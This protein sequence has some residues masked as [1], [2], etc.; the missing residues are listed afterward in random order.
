VNNKITEDLIYQFLINNE[1]LEKLKSNINTFNPFKILK[2]QEHEIRHSNIISWVFDPEGNHNLDDKVFKR[3][4]LEIILNPENE[5]NLIDSLNLYELQ[6]NSYMDIKVFRE[7]DNIDLLLVS[8]INKTVIFIENKVNSN[9]HSNQLNRYFDIVKEKYQGYKLI[10]VY[11]T[12]DGKEPSNKKYL[13]ASYY[14]L[15]KVLNITLELYKERTSAEI[16]RFLNY[17]LS[18]LKEKLFMDSNIKKLCNEIYKENKEVIDLIYSIGNE[19]DIEPSIE[20]FIKEYPEINTTFSNNKS[21]WFTI[22]EFKEAKTMNQTWGGGIPISYWFSEYYGS[23]KIVLEIGPFDNVSKRVEFMNELKNNNIKVSPRAME[24]IRKYTRLY[25]DKKAIKDWSDTQEI[26]DTMIAL[27]KSTK[28]KKIEEQLVAS[29]R[30]F[31]W[32]Y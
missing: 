3:F 4:L 18:L 24:P 11:L 27:F 17:Y 20:G 14:D 30:K 32:K 13:I 2:I 31:D 6:K 23:L 19:I 26:T 15:Y 25:T 10:P 9:E 21:F 5:N 1:R 16:I 29:I 12:L 28:L 22:P 8:D 7:Q